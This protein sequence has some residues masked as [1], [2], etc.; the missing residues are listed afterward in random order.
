MV[1]YNTIMTNNL[2]FNN[3]VAVP[4]F[5]SNNGI[6]DINIMTTNKGKPYF[7]CNNGIDGKMSPAALTA[8]QT[9]DL[10]DVRVSLCNEVGNTNT[11]FMIHLT[12]SKESNHTR[13]LTL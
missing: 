4:V 6:K 7:R 3:T 9:G 11:F 10:T 12:S 5:K 8:I 13:V 2:E 1:A